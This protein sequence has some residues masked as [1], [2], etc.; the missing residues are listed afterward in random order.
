MKL[1]LVSPDTNGSKVKVLSS[2]WLL[3]PGRH[4]VGAYSRICRLWGF[5]P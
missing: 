4:G 3:L 5:S 2:L 1:K